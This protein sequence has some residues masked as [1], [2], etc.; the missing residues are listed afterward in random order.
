MFSRRTFLKYTGGTALTLFAAPRV[1]GARQAVAQIEGG[2][3]DPLLVPK[4][5]TPL[6]IPP[7]APESLAPPPPQPITKDTPNNVE[8]MRRMLS[9]SRVRNEAMPTPGVAASES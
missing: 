1:G 8:D 9:S 7:V 3:L 5:V 6:L 4:Y 2:S